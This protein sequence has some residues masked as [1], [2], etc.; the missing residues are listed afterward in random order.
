MRRRIFV[1]SSNEALDVAR[2]VGEVLATGDDVKVDLW[3]EIFEPG[4]LTFEALEIMLHQCCAAVF[5]ASPDDEMKIRDKMVKCPRANIMLEFGLVAGRLGRHSVAVC[6]Y[7]GAELPSDLA[8]L[9]VIRMDPPEGEPDPEQYRRL[10]EQRLRLWSSRLLTTADGISRTDTLHGYTG[11]W[12]IDISLQ[13]W[14]DYPVAAPGFVQV[15]GHLDLY[16]PANGQVGRGLAHGRLQFKLPEGGPGKGLYHG[17]YRTAHDVI[18]AVCQKDGSL[19]LTTEAF[20]LQRMQSIGTPP[21][22]LAEI[23][24]LPEPWSARWKLSPSVGG[25]TLEG[26]LRTEGSIVS[27]G[28]V[29]ATQHSGYPT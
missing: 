19:E 21:P 4:Y 14:R 6:Q 11:R 8:G 15:K 24:L 26:V 9:T 12:D 28:I 7:G 13:K 20:A 5:V 22:E 17:E 1:G 3:T 25:R 29:K 10:A 16:I 23:D 2:H 18:D 27:E